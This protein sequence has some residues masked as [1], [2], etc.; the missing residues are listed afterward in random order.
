M[1][2]TLLMKFLPML[3]LSVV[4][5]LVGFFIVLWFQRGFLIAFLRVKMSRGKDLL[6][7][8]ITTMGKRAVYGKVKGDTVHYKYLGEK[9]TVD[10]SK[11]GKFLYYST[12][13]RMVEVVLGFTVPLKLGSY[14]KPPVDSN[15][16]DNLVNR[17]LT[18]PTL[19]LGKQDT[20]LLLV[21]I[22]VGALML[23]VWYQNG[24]ILKIVQSLQPVVASSVIP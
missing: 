23:W 14:E 15:I 4:S 17:A 8:V 6:V 19:K 11:P 21:I 24:E 18:R 22:G 13:V 16:T 9:H 5:M 3:L 10:I 1:A 12:G 20:I 7:W 2:E